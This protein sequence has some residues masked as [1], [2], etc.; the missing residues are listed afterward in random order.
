MNIKK[1]TEK[2][3]SQNPIS[4]RVNE[5]TYFGISS[6]RKITNFTIPNIKSAIPAIKRVIVIVL[7][8]VE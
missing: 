3:P 7:K 1:N 5:L 2:N 6:T 8:Y 4:L